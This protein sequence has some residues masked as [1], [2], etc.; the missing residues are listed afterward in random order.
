MATPATVAG[1]IPTG[2]E[3][4]PFSEL[5]GVSLGDVWVATSSPS[6]KNQPRQ[7]AEE[8]EE[9][10]AE[11]SRAKGGF[12]TGP[13]WTTKRD[14]EVRLRVD[15]SG[16]G[17]ELPITVH[18]L[19][20]ASVNKYGD[21]PA[22]ASKKQGQ[23]TTLT[24]R[25]YYEQCRKAAKSF[26]KLGLARFHSVGILGF[27]SLEW[28]LADVGAIFA[29]G[30]AVGIYTTNSPEACHY[31][32]ENCG[33]NII[34]VENDKQLQKILEI[35]KK[36]PLLKAIIQYSGEIKEKRPNLYSWDEFMALGSSVPDEQLD[37]ILASLKANQCCTII[38]TSGTT[39]NPK[40]VML[41][42]DNI[43]WTARASGEYVGLKTALED[44]ESV[45]SYLP[46][47]HIAAQ[48]IDIWLPITFGVQTFFADP[49]ALKGSLV[50]TLREVRPT[51]FMGVPR[52]WEKMQER[53]KSVGAKSSTL[54]K[55]IAFWAKAVGLETNL[56]RMNGCTELPMSY[57]LA[58]ALIY[59]KIRKALGLDRCNK[60][61]TGA[62]PITKDTLEYF[63]SLDIV[64]Y[65]LY[66]MSESSGPH[67]VSHPESYR[68]T[69]CGREI[70]GCK[71][72]LF[73]P[74]HDGVGEVC[75]GGRHIFMGY[76]NMDDKTK[77]AIDAEG[78]LH[79]GDLGRYDEDGFLYIT[80]RIKE[81]IITAGGENIPPI[82]IEDAIKEAV[83]ILSNVMLVGDKAK[84][85]VMLM[86][87]KSKVNLETGLSEDELTPEAIEF[88]QKLGSKSTKVSDIVG[89]KDVA[90]YT[91]IQKG[92]LKVNEHATSNA[93]K[94]QKWVLLDKDFSI[95]GGELGPTMKLKRPVVVK[96]YQDQIQ[97]LYSEASNTNNF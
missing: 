68:M 94:I 56:K 77:E 45:V 33:A 28:F 60:C 7:P 50:D 62:A 36:L 12:S 46:L 64:V 89:N 67:T 88:C 35:E 51:A 80:G 95:Q 69:S 82:P 6:A 17:S 57:R 13:V 86:T 19:F 18:E 4:P 14:G 58:K 74:D 78:W 48:M 15:E 25:Q 39:G 38:Y 59:T 21:F 23:W 3:T 22:L 61:Y 93:Q 20:L 52:V 10:E 83:P 70:T 90:V 96:M 92:V 9:A 41:S 37:K 5:T 73:K 27:N 72:M 79:S 34:V 47:S 87:I 31:V 85:L 81:L 44:Q 2:P 26:L 40:G 29:G 16:I 8:A 97:Q 30:F 55:K 11:M 63:L 91:A 43:T 76:L 32:A 65:E 24:Y 42:H 53:M 71:T 84:Y 54:K 75:F 66:G 49:D 1:S